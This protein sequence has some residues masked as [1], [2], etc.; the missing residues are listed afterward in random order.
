MF[1]MLDAEKRWLRR[2]GWLFPALGIPLGCLIV[3]AR[4]AAIMMD[5]AFLP[6]TATGWLSANGIALGVALG[7]F[8]LL[9]ALGLRLE[10][11]WGNCL[12]RCGVAPLGALAMLLCAEGAA[13]S[14]FG[15]ETL[16][17]AV[18]ARA[19]DNFF[20][21]E[22]ALFRLEHV[23]HCRAPRG[24]PGVVVAGSSQ[25]L[26]ALDAPR[27]AQRIGR[28]VYRRAVA[29]MFPVELC[30]A[31]GFL[32]FD[33]RN[34]MLLMLSGF[35]LGGRDRLY[36]A[37]IRP[38]ATLSGARL[39]AAAADWRFALDHWRTFVDVFAAGACE[40]WRSRDFCRL[41]VQHPFAPEAMKY[42]SAKNGGDDAQR[43][44]YLALG[45]N[46]QLVAFTERALTRFFAHMRE[47]MARVVV[48]E[49]QMNPA[50]PGSD[51]ARMHARMRALLQD[52]AAAG[53]IRF[54]P[55]EAQA[56]AI[57]TG[58]WLDMAH[59]N[60]RGRARYTEIFAREW[61]HLTSP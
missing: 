37:A 57:E 5:A 59:V 18:R 36:P 22:V 40:L 13:R 38:L 8:P 17:Q 26:H 3:E 28:P 35:D 54:V 15:Q 19:G 43:E 55:L 14:V 58:D 10:R 32:A 53:A 48:I 4:W 6:R 12:R 30:A 16:W 34:E 60:E 52:S 1:A 33:H 45:R 9:W 49:G 61:H 39:L 56:P 31:A 47:R 20:A 29:G 41:V 23:S 2:W 50:Y 25:M 51:A 42:V 7:L 24:E 44:A 11:R 46:E 27:L 21:R